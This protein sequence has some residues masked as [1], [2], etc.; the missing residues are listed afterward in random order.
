MLAASQGAAPYLL[1]LKTPDHRPC[2][3]DQRGQAGQND[4]GIKDHHI[5][6]VL[7]N[8]KTEAVGVQGGGINMMLLAS[9]Y[10][11]LGNSHILE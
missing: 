10:N 3:E 7:L 2:A 9:F 4:K 8:W 1:K 11:D 5:V 6:G